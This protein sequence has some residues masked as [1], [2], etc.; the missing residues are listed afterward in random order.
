M[1]C[2]RNSLMQCDIFSNVMNTFWTCFGFG[3]SGIFRYRNM[4]HCIRDVRCSSP[5]WLEVASFIRFPSTDLVLERWIDEMTLL[6]RLVPLNM[7][8]SQHL[9]VV[10]VSGNEL[11]HYAGFI[12]MGLCQRIGKLKLGATI[13]FFFLKKN[14]KSN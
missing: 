3:F 13:Y 5:W 2:N 4:S 14:W 11:C 7:F 12:L 9:F 8:S 6:R 1:R 10:E